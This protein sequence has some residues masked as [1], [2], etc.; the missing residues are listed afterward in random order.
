MIDINILY[1]FCYKLF[2]LYVI[3]L[4]ILFEIMI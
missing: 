1:E 4:T 3:D 2:N